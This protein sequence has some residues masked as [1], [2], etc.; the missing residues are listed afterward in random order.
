MMKLGTIAQI[1]GQQLEDDA[2]KVSVGVSID[3]RSL[4]PG[5][6]FLA[7]K[8][9]N[10]DGHDFIESAHQNG[11]IAIIAERPK[12]NLDLPQFIVPSSL[13]TLGQLASYHRGQINC[14]VIALTGS[15]GKT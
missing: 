5:S 15:N 13:T 6:V 12:K 1:L 2:D 7:L 11:A 14:P 8:G 10:F 4:E 3:S 9:D